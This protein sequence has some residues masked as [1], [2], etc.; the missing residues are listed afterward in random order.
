MIDEIV[1]ENEVLVK[2]LD[3]KNQNQKHL[4]VHNLAYRKAKQRV[5]VN[6]A[7]NLY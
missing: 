7:W 3:N 5:I 6:D 2:L 1:D 4:L